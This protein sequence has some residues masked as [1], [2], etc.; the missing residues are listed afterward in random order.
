MQCIP[1]FYGTFCKLKNLH[2]RI[3][4][5]N[6]VVAKRFY[7]HAEVAMTM[8]FITLRPFHRL[9]EPFQFRTPVQSGTFLPPPF[10]PTLGFT[11]PP[12]SRLFLLRVR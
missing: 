6:S 9:W 12:P 4:N 8:N 7:S 3:V 10:Q 1:K 5:V 11:K 2:S